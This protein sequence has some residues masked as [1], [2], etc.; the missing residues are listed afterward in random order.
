[1][2]QYAYLLYLSFS[3]ECFGRLSLPVNHFSSTLALASRGH[4]CPQRG[5]LG[6]HDHHYLL[7]MRLWASTW[8]LSPVQK[9]QKVDVYQWAK[10]GCAHTYIYIYIYIFFFFLLHSIRNKKKLFFVCL[11]MTFLK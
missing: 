3:L 10:G 1:M 9:V 2:L 8:A 11:E 4:S 5:F 6:C 7:H